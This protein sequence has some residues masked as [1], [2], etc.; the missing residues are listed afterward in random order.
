MLT[1]QAMI[2]WQDWLSWPWS[3][4]VAMAITI[5]SLHWRYFVRQL[6]TMVTRLKWTSKITSLCLW[7]NVI[8]WKNNKSALYL[9]KLVYVVVRHIIKNPSSHVEIGKDIRYCIICPVWLT[10]ARRHS[11]NQF[12]LSMP[13]PNIFFEKK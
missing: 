5:S 6:L 9:L 12:T 1:A 3:A 8:H 4:L 11:I 10:W 2:S 13:I 7:Q